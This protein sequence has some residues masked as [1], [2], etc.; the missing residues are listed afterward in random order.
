MAKYRKKPVVIE[1]IQW[2]PYLKIDE[3]IPYFCTNVYRDREDTHC[4]ECRAVLSRHGY[5]HTLEGGHIVC[6]GDWIITGIKGEKYPCKPDIFEQT[7][8]KV[9]WMDIVKETK[10]ERKARLK[11]LDKFYKEEMEKE[12]KTKQIC[13][14]TCGSVF[15]ENELSEP[16]GLSGIEPACPF[17]G[18]KDLGEYE[19][20]KF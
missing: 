7:Y 6:P 2:Y 8:E 16:Y 15:N 14:D 4:K 20:F 13:C 12:N 9:D 3:V 17:C 5:I 18:G 19:L 1:A 11:K 10:K